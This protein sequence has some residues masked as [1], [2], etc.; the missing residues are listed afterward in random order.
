MLVGS[1]GGGNQRAMV[2]SGVTRCLLELALSSNAPSALR[3]QALNT[4]SPIMMTS[5]ENQGLLSNL[6]MAPLVAVPADEEHPN[7]GFVRLPVRPATLALVGS[8]IDGESGMGG[9]GLRS[10]AAGSN[11]FEVSWGLCYVPCG[12]LVVAIVFWV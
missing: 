1:P 6:S 3:A 9:K 2:T 7:G 11:M 4:L 5:P 10:R 8:V 12:I